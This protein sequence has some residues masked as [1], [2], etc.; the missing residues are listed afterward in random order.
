MF[1]PS[2][3]V[4]TKGVG[5]WCDR[6][7]T[8]LITTR[9][10]LIIGHYGSKRDCTTIAVQNRTGPHWCYIYAV[11][12]YNSLISVH[13]LPQQQATMVERRL[14]EIE[15]KWRVKQA[16]CH[17]Q[18][19]W[20]QGKESSILD[21]LYPFGLDIHRS[22]SQI[23]CCGRIAHGN[24]GADGTAVDHCTEMKWKSG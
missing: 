3:T 2:Q 16:L 4:I 12:G 10:T 24:H 21:K 15:V 5:V 6:P 1:I 23:Q 8:P 19:S 7:L 9:Q 20:A 13:P 14:K 17:C 22:E 18:N 11:C